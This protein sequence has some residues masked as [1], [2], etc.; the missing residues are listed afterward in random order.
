MT[1][2][3]LDNK[4]HDMSEDMTHGRLENKTDDRLE[5]ETQQIWV[6]KHDWLEDSYMTAGEIDNDSLEHKT[7]DTWKFGG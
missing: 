2:D 1:Y 4:S 3:R 7:H 5:I 6:Q